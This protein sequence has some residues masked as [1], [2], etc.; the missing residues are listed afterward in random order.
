MKVLKKG[1][2]QKGWTKEFT[3]SGA[4]NG[5]GGCGAE[6]LVDGDYYMVGTCDSGLIDDDCAAQTMGVVYCVDLSD[7]TLNPQDDLLTDGYL[8]SI[9]VDPSIGSASKTGYYVKRESTGL[10]T[11]GACD[12]EDAAT[13]ESSR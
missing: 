12:P 3:C 5:N 9:P 11:I 13:I 2:G 1:N 4:G 8:G 6:L 10:I 7:S